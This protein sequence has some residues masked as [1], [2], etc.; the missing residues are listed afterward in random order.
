M[1]GSGGLD[2]AAVVLAT[3]HHCIIC[4]CMYPSNLYKSCTQPT[5]FSK[6]HSMLSMQGGPKDVPDVW[7]QL[8]DQCIRAIKGDLISK[9]DQVQRLEKHGPPTDEEHQ[10]V[11]PSWAPPSRTRRPCLADARQELAELE[12]E[13]AEL[14]QQWQHLAR[15]PWGRG[16]HVLV[17]RDAT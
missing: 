17:I 3:C 8:L 6:M 7:L 2:G 16:Q 12:Q 1:N 11:W 15:W 9:R 4:W 5:M 14:E 10:A 13:S